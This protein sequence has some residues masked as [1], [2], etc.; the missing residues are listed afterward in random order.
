MNKGI[1]IRTNGKVEAIEIGGFKGMQGAVD[2]NIECALTGDINEDEHWDLWGNEE[3]RLLE[4]PMN[5]V[6][7][8]FIAEMSDIPIEQVFSLHGD[9]LLLGHDGE[10]ASIDCPQSVADIA[11]SLTMFNEPFT[12]LKTSKGDEVLF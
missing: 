3:G 4:L 11:M 6:A 1:L 5:Q 7:R 9:F 2:G 12:V 10:G 8:V